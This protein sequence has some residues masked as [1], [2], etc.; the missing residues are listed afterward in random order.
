MKE[1]IS[2]ACSGPYVSDP[3]AYIQ[4][5]LDPEKGETPVLNS[6]GVFHGKVPP[7]DFE[8]HVKR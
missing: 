8:K 1:V 3:Y 2:L 4:V 5:L 6:K 7:H